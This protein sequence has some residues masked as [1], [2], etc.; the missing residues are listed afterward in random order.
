MKNKNKKNIALVLI[1]LSILLVLAI[2]LANAE[3]WG[4]FSKGDKINYCNP[5]IPDRT[6]SSSNYKLCMDEYD[7]TNKCYSPGNWNVCNTLSGACSG[8][9]GGGGGEIDTVAPI[10]TLTSPINNSIYTSRNVP[11]SFTL[12]E[13]SDVYYLDMVNGKGKWTKV[14]SDC[15]SYSKSRSLKDGQNNLQFK[16]VDRND[17]EAYLNRHFFVD[18]KAPKITTTNPRKGFANGVFNVI[19]AE[20]NP[21]NI[22]LHYGNSNTGMN[23]KTLNLN[24]DCRDAK[25][26]KICDTNVSLLSY[27]DQQIQY[28]FI[29]RDIAGNT[30][31]SKIINLNVDSSAPIINKINYT[32]DKN[33]VTFRINV[34]EQN[35]DSI[36]YLDNFDSRPRWRTICSKLKDGICEKKLTLKT[37]S[38]PINIRALDDAGNII[39]S[40]I[41]VEV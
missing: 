25:T 11:F 33:K 39:V 41:N 20:D 28:W 16:A 17:N 2:N 37:G 21:A 35:L 38:H 23:E 22:V 6:A 32:I 12:N 13:K 27:N 7:E 4:C 24:N 26:K 8:T 1:V 30:D 40:L 9:G 18:S 3:F 34:T 15:I 5:N 10:L 14:C 29:V 36:D 31:D 19:F